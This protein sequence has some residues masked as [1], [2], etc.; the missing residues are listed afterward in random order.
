MT[1]PVLSAPG[2]AFLIGEYAVLHGATALITAIGVR[3]STLADEPTSAPS[4]MVAAARAGVAAALSISEDEL[5]PSPVVDTAQFSPGR[6]KLGLGS[7]AAVTAVIVGHHLTAAGYRLDDPSTRARVL[8]IARAAHRAAQGGKGSGADVAASVLGRTIAFQGGVARPFTLPAW[9][10]IGFFDAG[11]PASTTSLVGAVAAARAKHPGPIDAALARMR[12]AS[13]RLRDALPDIARFPEL[14]AAV[15]QHCQGLAALQ[16]ESDAPILTPTI[17]TILAAARAAGLAAKPSG[18]GGGDLVVVFSPTQEALDRL[19]VRLYAEAG[20]RPLDLPVADAGLRIDPRPPTRSR[21]A[22]FFRLG[23]A[24]RRA[25]IARAAGLEPERLAALDRGLDLAA[26]EHMIENVVG[27]LSLPLAVATNFQING[28]DVLVPMCVEEASVVAAASNA[29]KMIRAGGG[30][31][32]HADPP[33]MV[34]QIQLEANNADPAEAARVAARIEAAEGELLALADQAHP[35]LVE[36]GGGARDLEVRV[37]APDMIVVHAIVDCRDAMGAN[38]LNTI[39]ES[40]APPLEAITGWR[41]GLRILSNLAVHRCAHVVARVPPAALARK[42]WD[43]DEVVRLVAAASRFAE[44]DPFRA[45]THNKGIMNGV[46]A[47]VLAT[48]NDWRAV[49]AAAHAYAARDGQYRPLATWR[50][51]DDGWLS[52]RISMPTAVGMVGGATRAHPIARV[53]LEILG[54]AS[55]SD[56]GVVIAAAG[57]ASNLAALRAL[58]TEGIQRGHMSLHARTLALAAGAHGEE[59]EKIARALIQSG[60][61]KQ[62]RAAELLAALRA[63]DVHH[64]TRGDRGGA[65]E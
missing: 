2:K 39:A 50:R 10:R 23:I 9:L 26:A 62:E 36:R 34:T 55:G 44:L 7:S 18:A 58:A 13:D 45:T 4:P 57:L 30:F 47:V 51:D 54:C 65:S 5:G 8:E 56:L 12:E 48:G 33:W 61:I 37:L 49:E 14:R 46:D 6:R 15:E 24:G 17:A 60:E 52:G 29:A 28:R 59:I 25:A 43:G 32:A 64:T 27:L 31:V 22:G 11:Q 20:V 53:A 1:A 38:L 16:A 63:S 40:L 19:A 21:F 35:R 41:A 42:G 3:A